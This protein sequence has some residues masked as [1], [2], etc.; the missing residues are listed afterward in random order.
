[1][2]NI[3]QVGGHVKCLALDMRPSD[4][5]AFQ[6]PYIMNGLGTLDT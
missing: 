3:F 4:D 2:W 6:L 5:D 1:M